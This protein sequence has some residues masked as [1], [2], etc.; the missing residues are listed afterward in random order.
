MTGTGGV[1]EVGV[2]VIGAMVGVVGP[3]LLGDVP[4]DGG[5]DQDQGGN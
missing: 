2:V 1:T 5:Q 4:A 3:P